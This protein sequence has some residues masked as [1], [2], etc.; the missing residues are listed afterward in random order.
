MS[1]I[2]SRPSARTGVSRRNRAIVPFAGWCRVLVP[3]GR[4]EEVTGGAGTRQSPLLC[5]SLLARIS[6]RD[7]ARHWTLL[8]A[9]AGAGFPL[10][11][12]PFASRM[13]RPTSTWRPNST[14]SAGPSSTASWRGSGTCGRASPGE[15]PVSS[16]S[17]VCQPSLASSYS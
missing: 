5:M 8:T 3:Y 4:T 7:S 12:E 9:R 16:V 13:P 11:E 2:S 6:L 14:R 17:D 10:S 15:A 1:T